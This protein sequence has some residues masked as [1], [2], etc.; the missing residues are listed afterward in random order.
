VRT[1]A[2]P[3]LA[4]SAIACRTPGKGDPGTTDTAGLATQ[5]ADGDGY[6]ADE[7]CDDDDPTVHPGGTE[8][9]DGVDNDCDDETDEGVQDTWYADADG[10]GYGDPGAATEACDAPADHVASATDCDDTDAD[11]HPAGTERCNGQDDDCDGAVDEEVQG[12]WFADMDGDGFGDAGAPLDDC[13]PPE[14][15]VADATDCDDTSAATRPGADEV[16]DGQDNDCDGDIDEDATATFYA[17]ADGDGHGDAT[18]AAEACDAPSGFVATDDDCDDTDPAVNPGAS[19]SCN[20]VDDD[21]DGTTDEADAVDASVWYADTDADGYG[22]VSATTI[23]CAAPSGSV[24][25]GT[26]CDDTDP[27][28]HPAAT[29]VCNSIDDDCDGDIDD[30]DASVDHTTG[31]TFYADAD[32]DGYGDATASTDACVAPSGTVADATDC[33]DAAASVHPGATEVCN[34]I[35]DDCDGDIDDDDASLDASTASTWYADGDADGFGDAGAALTACA[36]PGGYGSDATDC[37]DADATVNP[38]A[39]EV[40]NGQDDDCDGRDD[41]GV[42]GSGASCPGDDCLDILTDGSSVGDGSYW[43]LDTGVAAETECDMT[44]DGGGWTL[45]FADDF[46]TAPDPAWSATGTYL[47]PGW[48]TLLGGYG[49]QA[50]G[51]LDITVDTWGITHTDA[52]VALSY[53]KLDSWDGELAWVSV[54]GATVW[55]QNLYYYEGSEVCGWNR[56]WNGS[57]DELHAISEVTGH[58]GSTLTV[59]AGSTLNQV[60]TDESF[61]I[62]DVLVWV[63]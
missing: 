51:T 44:T 27:A 34:S 8:V 60:A 16:C 63:R 35:D 9:C 37:D 5:D 7:D 31:S 49:V 57:Y 28:V 4:L 58:T 18:R 14:G 19:E 53:A 22:D 56:G 17:D 54:D 33:D 32:A 59:E 41:D 6:T 45:V 13:D 39:A 62:D 20:G 1:V 42:L 12:T 61:G 25:D 10:D 38:A 21:C 52:W 47:C 24:A 40:C 30:D 2:V 23:A 43:V 50:G 15:T 46:E 48:T 29:E 11:I 36:A 3:L 55:S 26:D